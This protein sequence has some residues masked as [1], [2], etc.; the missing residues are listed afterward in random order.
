MAPNLE[1]R[2]CKQHQRSNIVLRKQMAIDPEK[3][4][5]I[6][7]LL[8]CLLCIVGQAVVASL[9]L[10]SLPFLVKMYFPGV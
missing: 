6:G 2:K 5:H 1:C 8:S 3:G 9:I 4:L 10:P 7:T